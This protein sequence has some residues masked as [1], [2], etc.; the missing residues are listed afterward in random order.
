MIEHFEQHH[1]PPT[2]Q[3]QQ[4]RTDADPEVAEQCQGDDEDAHDQPAQ[5][6]VERKGQCTRCKAGGAQRQVDA[7]RGL[8][9]VPGV[10]W[11]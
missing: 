1:V 11:G 3:E 5:A 9:L 10:Q 2:D 8:D 6:Q 7:L 4:Q